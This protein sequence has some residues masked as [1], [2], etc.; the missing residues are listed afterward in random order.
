[1]T[2]YRVVITFKDSGVRRKIIERP[3]M[4]KAIETANGAEESIASKKLSPYW[5]GAAVKIE[6]RE[7]GKWTLLD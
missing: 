7:V 5:T 6:A 1:M 2:E 4:A 3:S